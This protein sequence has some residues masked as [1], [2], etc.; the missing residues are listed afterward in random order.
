MLGKSQIGW[1][2]SLVPS[3]PSWNEFLAI[4]VKFYIKVNIKVFCCLVFRFLEG[5]RLFLN[6]SE[7]VGFS[8]F[9]VS[10]LVVSLSCAFCLYFKLL[11]F[12]GIF[13][14]VGFFLVDAS[15]DLIFWSPHIHYF[16][17]VVEYTFG[18]VNFDVC[19]FNCFITERDYIFH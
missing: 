5:L 12:L 6:T 11:N 10:L 1:G 19:F 8:V 17:N 9:S 16:L 18:L 15:F 13:V 3:L 7:Y 14:D 4:A 2:Q